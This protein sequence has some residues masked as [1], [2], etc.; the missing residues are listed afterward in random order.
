M[1]LKNQWLKLAGMDY[2]V[3]P[4]TQFNATVEKPSTL[5]KTNTLNE[6]KL[7]EARGNWY[8]YIDTLGYEQTEAPDP[9]R[10][11]IGPL[12]S[13]KA[14]ARARQ[15]LAHVYG[16]AETRVDDRGWKTYVNH[17]QPTSETVETDP[18]LVYRVSGALQPAHGYWNQI[19][20]VG[21]FG[22][23][24]KKTGDMMETPYGVAFDSK[25]EAEDYLKQ[26]APR[27]MKA[28]KIVNWA[29][30][31]VAFGSSVEGFVLRHKETGETKRPRFI[32]Q[33]TAEEYLNKK[34]AKEERKNWKIDKFQLTKEDI[35]SVG[36][37]G[38]VI[39]NKKTNVIKSGPYD[40]RE[41]ADEYIKRSTA[42]DER[43]NWKVIAHKALGF[44]NEPNGNGVS[45]SNE[46]EKMNDSVFLEGNKNKKKEVAAPRATNLNAALRSKKSGGHFSDK[47][48]YRRSKEKQ[49]AMRELDEAM[50]MLD[51]KNAK[52]EL[53]KKGYKQTHSVA[54]DD[55][56]GGVYF[57]H[58]ETKE[59]AVIRKGKI[60]YDVDESV[61]SVEI[62][63][64]QP[65]LLQ[66]IK[67]VN[68]SG[69][70]GVKAGDN[71]S[72]HNGPAYAKPEYRHPDYETTSISDEHSKLGGEEEE[73]VDVPQQYGEFKLPVEVKKAVQ[74]SIA[75]CREMADKTPEDVINTR[76]HSDKSWWKNTADMLQQALDWMETG[77]EGNLKRAIT[78]IQS[79]ENA[80]WWSWPP[81][82]VKFMAHYGYGYKYPSLV[83]RFKEIKHNIIP[84]K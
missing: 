52:N 63:E 65:F 82:L 18:S 16:R 43:S 44:G 15:L 78:L 39:I 48:D 5:K 61:E 6:A 45:E 37:P 68:Q 60:H 71:S 49:K 13:S 83:D 42:G 55:G 20:R 35:E 12:P 24:N 23:K 57:R 66:A 59:Y 69:K 77:E 64:N 17:D 21:G 14:A 25:E 81:E 67:L 58:P 33:T 72:K 22:L 29:T 76:G 70:A 41:E 11:S 40:T 34:V 74:R 47:S 4:S 46:D 54:S 73:G 62:L 7:E 28:W 31:C 2:D 50:T 26:N 56:D 53:E 9:D 79:W 84:L 30:E 1:D 38:F 27:N 19:S 10:P 8:L 3:R 75:H 51:L 36:Q 80:R 32:T